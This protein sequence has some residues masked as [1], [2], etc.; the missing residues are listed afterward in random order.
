[1]MLQFVCNIS[2]LDRGLAG[3][4]ESKMKEEGEEESALADECVLIS[5]SGATIN[6]EQECF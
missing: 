5:G 2:M 4:P 3:L 6:I 1:M